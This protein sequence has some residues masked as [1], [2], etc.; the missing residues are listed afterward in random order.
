MDRHYIEFTTPE[1]VDVIC[2][3]LP[4]PADDEVLISVHHAGINRAD[5]LGGWAYPPPADVPPVPG[6]EVAGEV[7][8]SVPGHTS[9]SEPGLCAD[10]WR[11]LRHPRNGP[12]GP[13]PD[14]PRYPDHQKGA[15]F[16]KRFTVWYNVV[17]RGQLSAGDTVLSTEAVDGSIGGTVATMG[18]TV[19][20]TLAS[21]RC[22]AVSALGAHFVAN[23]RDGQ[24]I[25]QFTNAGYAGEIDVI[26]DIAGRPDAG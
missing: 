10:P 13:L 24:L 18:A 16:L 5:L 21:G 26:L 11:R 1:T 14:A 23:H 4:S 20:S 8:A 19:L 12:R 7:V 17:K 3:Q 9:R 15:A 22:D 25:E 6:L 2:D